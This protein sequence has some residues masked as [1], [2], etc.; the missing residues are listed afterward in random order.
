MNYWHNNLVRLENNLEEIYMG[1]GGYGTT[2][3]E[4]INKKKMKWE[5]QARM[6]YLTLYKI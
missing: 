3:L 5:R 6:C 2:F 1:K 4:Y